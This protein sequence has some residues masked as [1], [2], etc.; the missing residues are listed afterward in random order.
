MIEKGKE[1]TATFATTATY[2]LTAGG[3]ELD[4]IAK[5]RSNPKNAVRHSDT[6]AA[7]STF[8]RPGETRTPADLTVVA[9]VKKPK[10]RRAS[11]DR[12]AFGVTQKEACYQA[13][14]LGGGTGRGRRRSR[15]S[16]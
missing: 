10:T 9:V 14:S 13:P 2:C 8:S 3:S 6:A 16:A 12:A 7:Q 4:A 5:I 1:V 15:M 11:G